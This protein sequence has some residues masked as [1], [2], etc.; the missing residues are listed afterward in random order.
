MKRM[1]KNLAILAMGAVFLSAVGCNR[2]MQMERYFSSIKVGQSSSVDVLNMLPQEGMLTV[3][4]SVSVLSEK[5]GNAE[6]GI[7]VFSDADSTVERMEYI[8]RK[9]AF[10]HVKVGVVISARIPASVLDQPYESEMHMRMAILRYLHQQLVEDIKP[11]K[12]DQQTESLMGLARTALSVGIHHLGTRPREAYKLLTS[13]G[14]DYEHPNM[15]KC[16][17]TLTESEDIYSVMIRTK[18]GMDPLVNW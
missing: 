4:N 10:P 12:D 2:P 6:V 3:T 7:V 5:G 1:L 8:Q 16:R 17:M 14:F 11:F 15:N 13:E 9:M 18:A